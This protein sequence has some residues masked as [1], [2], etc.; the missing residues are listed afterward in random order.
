MQM[1]WCSEPVGQPLYGHESQGHFPGTKSCTKQEML[2]FVNGT[3]STV[4]LRRC[5]GLMTFTSVLK[6]I[7]LS[8]MVY[9]AQYKIYIIMKLFSN[10][11]IVYER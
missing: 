5:Q 3:S 7:T 4:I 2:L 9:F 8:I 11:S 1:M 6:D 10:F